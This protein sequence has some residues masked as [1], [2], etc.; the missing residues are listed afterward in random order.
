MDPK[1]PE[2]ERAEFLA[3]QPSWFQKVLQLDYDSM[4][5]EEQQAW[6]SSDWWKLNSTY[7]R[8]QQEYE[9]ILRRIPAAW[10][11]HRWKLARLSPLLVPKGKL[12]RQRK[13]ALAEEAANLQ[14]AG[15]NHPQI[16]HELNRRHGQGTTTSEAVRK[17]LK[18]HPDKT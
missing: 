1:S 2:R 12:G 8:L 14:R 9:S 5:G 16:A 3:A 13:T 17:L 4:S 10:K 6:A 7:K 11:N 15:K 18:R